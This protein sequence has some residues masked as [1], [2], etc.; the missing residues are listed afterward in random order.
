M[1]HLVLLFWIKTEE[2]YTVLI[3]YHYLTMRVLK[4]RNY[5]IDKKM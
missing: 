1:Y 5:F 3:K 2:K 4:R